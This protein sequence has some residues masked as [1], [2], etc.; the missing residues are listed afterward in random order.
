MTLLREWLTPVGE[1]VRWPDDVLNREGYSP[2]A[3]RARIAMSENDLLALLAD[4]GGEW[5]PKKETLR[6]VD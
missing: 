3:D 1:L 5:R 2:P 4:P 6:Q